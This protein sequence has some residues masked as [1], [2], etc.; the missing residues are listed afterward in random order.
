MDNRYP[1]GNTKMIQMDNFPSRLADVVKKSGLTRSEFAKRSGVGVAAL[2]KWLSGKLMPKSEQLLSLAKTS[3]VTMEWL[4]TGK[5]TSGS[6]LWSDA[7]EK[8]DDGRLE[9][10]M[11]SVPGPDIQ[12]AVDLTRETIKEL[13]ERADMFGKFAENLR[14]DAERMEDHLEDFIIAVN[15]MAD[16][17]RLA[18]KTYER[19]HRQKDKDSPGS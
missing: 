11:L 9:A 19:R 3:D 6:E 17:A 10:L 5:E 12:E 7:Y 14:I 2:G 15:G 1:Y 13:R 18:V 16:R 8:M 4:L